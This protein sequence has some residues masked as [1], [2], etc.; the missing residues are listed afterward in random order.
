MMESWPYHQRER[1]LALAP[2]LHIE[3]L[4]VPG[5][6]GF[7]EPAADLARK[8]RDD[9]YVHGSA[10]WGVDTNAMA[11]AIRA[12]SAAN[13]S[14]LFAFVYDELWHPYFRLHKIFSAL[15][16]G[17]YRMLRELSIQNIEPGGAGWQPHR[18]KGRRALDHDG[19]PMSLTAWISLTQ[20]T[21]LEGCIYLVPPQH[22]PTYGTA[23]ET[24]LR[25]AYQSIRAVPAEAG[26]FLIW[27]QALVHWGG[28]T[29]REVTYSRVSMALQFQRADVPSLDG[30]LME[31]LRLLPLAARVKL[32]AQQL[33]RQRHIYDLDPKLVELAVE[34]G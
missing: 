12:L 32:I 27:N 2:A 25:F 18:D 7:L 14:P 6:S 29:C 28:K 23:E 33:Y 5:E 8:F 20:A 17:E 11:D 19:A 26:D 10:D 1:W 34:Q 24:E 30:P 22:D 9:G 21:P 31:P 4:S 3:E 15:L 16:G 13:L